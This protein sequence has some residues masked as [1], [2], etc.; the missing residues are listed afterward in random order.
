MNEFRLDQKNSDLSETTPH[1]INDHQ[2]DMRGI[3]VGWYAM[4]R[5]GTL[6]AGPFSS[7]EECLDGKHVLS[8]NRNL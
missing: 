2:S 6:T 5:D 8:L 4:G 1:H 7:R 3:K